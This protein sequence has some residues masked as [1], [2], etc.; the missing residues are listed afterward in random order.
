MFKE[1]L[2]L[3]KTRTA[4][5][6]C[7]N[8]KELHLGFHFGLGAGDPDCRVLAVFL[9]HKRVSWQSKDKKITLYPFLVI[10]KPTKRKQSCWLPYWHVEER[11]G[12]QRMKYGQWAPFM[13]KVQFA[14]LLR[15][16]RNAGYF[17]R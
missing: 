16:A 5:G 10:L 12:K 11:N 14:S 15:Q 13:E 9:P 2:S 6:H 7:G 8:N 3:S 17:P 1:L 4:C